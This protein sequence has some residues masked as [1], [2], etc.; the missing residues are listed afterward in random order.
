MNKANRATAASIARRLARV[1]EGLQALRKRVAIGAH[2]ASDTILL[3]AVN[4]HFQESQQALAALVN[5]V[6]EVPA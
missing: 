6:S 2:V 3:N 5:Q 1:D 4:A